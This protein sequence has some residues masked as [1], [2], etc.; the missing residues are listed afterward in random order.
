MKKT[1]Q[2][3]IEIAACDE[4]GRTEDEAEEDG[5]YF[6]TCDICGND[7]CGDCSMQSV[8][9]KNT[10]TYLCK[11]CD[12]LDID[13]YMELLDQLHEHQKKVQELSLQV[14]D[15]ILKLRQV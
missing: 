1:I 8:I 9:S 15:E 11:T 7:L 3:E 12:K 6:H 13:K 4:C 5:L 14:R 10:S 2:V